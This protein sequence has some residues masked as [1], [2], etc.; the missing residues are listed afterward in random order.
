MDRY[1]RADPPDPAQVL[2]RHLRELQRAGG[3]LVVD[4]A[5]VWR[6]DPDNVSTEVICG[7]DWGRVEERTRLTAG[8]LERLQ[9]AIRTVGQSRSLSELIEEG[10]RAV[11]SFRGADVEGLAEGA[12]THAAALSWALD[13]SDGPGDESRPLGVIL[14]GSADTRPATTDRLG[15]HLDGTTGAL[16]QTAPFPTAVWTFQVADRLLDLD[17]PEVAQRWL[18]TASG[19]WWPEQSAWQPFLGVAERLDAM[20]RDQVPGFARS[21]AAYLDS[22]VPVGAP[23]QVRSRLHAL[24]RATTTGELTDAL[25][26]LLEALCPHCDQVGP[27]VVRLVRATHPL[28]VNIPPG[29]GA[30][31]L[32]AAAAVSDNAAQHWRLEVNQTLLDHVAAGLPVPNGLEEFPAPLARRVLE[33]WPVQAVRRSWGSDDLRRYLDFI[34]DA[35]GR[36]GG[37]ADWAR[38]QWIARLFEAGLSRGVYGMLLAAGRLD[39]AAVDGAAAL[40]GA[41]GSGSSVARRVRDWDHPNVEGDEDVARV[42]GLLGAPEVEIVEYLHFRRIAEGVE[43]FP[44][45]VT[46]LLGDEGFDEQARMIEQRLTGATAADT[47]TGVLV[48]ELSRLRDPQV[49]AARRAAAARRARNQLRRGTTVFRLAALRRILEDEVRARL[50]ELP[51]HTPMGLLGDVVWLFADQDVNHELLQ[52]FL[53]TVVAGE[54]VSGWP[55]NERWLQE[56][57]RAGDI[58]VDTWLAGFDTT[59]DVEGEPIRY[60]T[61]GNPVLASHMG[62]WFGTCLALDDGFNRAAALTNAVEVNR[63]V[64]YGYDLSGNIVARKLIAISSSGGL[65]GYRTYAHAS[66]DVH[67]VNLSAICREFAGRCGLRLDSTGRPASLTGHFWYDDGTYRW[68]QRHDVIGSVESAGT[69]VPV[70]EV[71]DAAGFVAAMGRDH[72]DDAGAREVA[73]SS[74]DDQ[75]LTGLWLDDQPGV[76]G[77]LMDRALCDRTTYVIRVA[78]LFD[79]DG[80]ADEFNRWPGRRGEIECMACIPMI[81]DPGVATAVARNNRHQA[82][83]LNWSL[84][85]VLP[86]ALAVDYL[87]TS[88]TSPVPLDLIRWLVHATGSRRGVRRVA[89]HVQDC[90]SPEWFHSPGAHARAL[91]TVELLLSSDQELRKRLR[92]QSAVEPAAVELARRPSPQNALAVSAAVARWPDLPWVRIAAAALGQPAPPLDVLPDDAVD[93]QRAERADVVRLAI[94]RQPNTF[95]AAVTST[96]NPHLFGHLDLPPDGSFEREKWEAAV[97]YPA[98]I[99]AARNDD[100]LELAAVVQVDSC[101]LDF[102]ITKDLL[103]AA[104]LSD[105]SERVAACASFVADAVSLHRIDIDLRPLLAMVMARFSLRAADYPEIA[106]TAAGAVRSEPALLAALTQRLPDDEVLPLIATDL[107]VGRWDSGWDRGDEWIAA[108]RL[109]SSDDPVAALAAVE[110]KPLVALLS[111]LHGCLVTSEIVDLTERVLQARADA[112][113]ADMWS[114]AVRGNLEH[115][116]SPLQLA[117]ARE[118]MHRGHDAVADLAHM[119]ELRQDGEARREWLIGGLS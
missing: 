50:G 105:S 92:D 45:G 89:R 77:I 103:A 87:A 94:H 97:R 61:E 85:A 10:H 119:S 3:L 60:C 13:C 99:D 84:W 113:I 24:R 74:S 44:Q 70:Y 33:L 4:P 22:V 58:E 68:P 81:P 40:V 108:R 48:A 116:R 112:D 15:R 104:A 107:H 14:A 20:G 19:L 43:Q 90:W 23:P 46:S 16:L 53:K 30:N 73:R 66:V 91:A 39:A 88:V 93:P 31:N 8:D 47:E 51:L 2:G 18:E 1:G 9:R 52:R 42:A 75:L 96:E 102:A 59:R 76:R 62:S 100:W 71:G 63:H 114:E 21:A 38:E 26:A 109:R 95:T 12:R 69:S 78:P 54:P 111:Q 57:R 72:L 37:V 83:D 28:P 55:E 64:V 67:D 36:S 17:G 35:D 65:L 32:A 79:P 86:R 25:A 27:S 80:F 7:G 110:P 5:G 41:I 49:R 115:V 82:C 117:L 6:V 106:R 101:Y 56:V 29:C 11:R 34:A 118:I 98:A